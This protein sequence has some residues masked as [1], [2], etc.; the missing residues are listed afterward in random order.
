MLLSKEMLEKKSLNIFC[1]TIYEVV[2]NRPR[3]LKDIIRD[4][5]KKKNSVNP[6]EFHTIKDYFKVDDEEWD[7]IER[8]F[9]IKDSE[10][11]L[12][13]RDIMNS[14]LVRDSYMVTDSQSV[15][16]SNNV[17]KSTEVSGST[18]V[19]ESN[20]IT[21]SQFIFKSYFVKD[22]TD[23]HESTFVEDGSQNIHKSYYVFDSTNIIKSSF[24]NYCVNMENTYFCKLCEDCRNCMFCYAFSC[25][26]EDK[27]YFFN[28]E[29]SKEKFDAYVDALDNFIVY[30]DVL[31]EGL[32]KWLRTLPEFDEE[33]FNGI[34]RTQPWW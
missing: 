2:K 33:L 27:Y 12:R 6:Y 17:K 15:V 24:I 34:T 32:E 25:N 16:D 10:F 5:E 29:V 26:E 7:A 8:I 19:F 22:S 9:N 30:E 11:V 1:P 23:V 13:S 3:E 21:D 20:H 14:K 31:A 28:K 4:Y 18:N